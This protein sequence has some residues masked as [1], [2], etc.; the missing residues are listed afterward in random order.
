MIGL[1]FAK[2]KSN[3]GFTLIESIVA[4]FLF[5]ISFSGLFLFFGT[6]Q[7][8]SINTQKKMAINMMAN[9]IIEM[10]A[11]EAKR[12]TDDPMNPFLTPAKYSGDLH[13]CSDYAV[14]DLRFNWCKEL[15]EHAGPFNGFDNEE[16]KIQL[17]LDGSNLIIN[18]SI[19]V[20]ASGDGKTFVQTYLSRKLRPN[21]L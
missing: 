16:R 8:S 5:A 18:V 7:Q 11:I 19:I 9:E 12:A 21:Q 15:E 1:I 10:I 3:N 20:E 14:T 13:K 6:A 4:L 2:I 17:F